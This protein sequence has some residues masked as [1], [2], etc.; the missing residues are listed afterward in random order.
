MAGTSGIN[1]A[2]TERHQDTHYMDLQL[3]KAFLLLFVTARLRLSYRSPTPRATVAS[4][5]VILSF[6]ER[7]IRLAAAI[8][9]VFRGIFGGVAL[10]EAIT[11]ISTRFPAAAAIVKKVVPA[12]VLPHLGTNG[13]IHNISLTGATLIGCLLALV[14]T[15]IRTR[16][17][18]ELGKHF[19]FE[20]SL[21]QDHSLV[22]TGPYSI[23]RHPSYTAIVLA[24]LSLLLLHGTRGS[25]V[26]ESGMLTTTWG[27]TV[28]GFELTYM[29]WM[30]AGLLRRM[31]EEDSVLRK[32][33]GSKWEDWVT[34][35]PYKLWP[36]MI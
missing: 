9:P 6:W 3:L 11:I 12:L 28:V 26:R 29:V 31:E 18:R 2:S 14:A 5:A 33:F 16:C 27:K 25:W 13:S 19:T 17:Y 30:T 22:T 1:I 34:K 15:Y 24:D 23:V 10:A 21:Q 8:A 20:L 7:W 36:G 35:V 32:R 4:G